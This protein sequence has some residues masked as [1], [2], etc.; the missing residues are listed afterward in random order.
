MKF[1]NILKW[2]QRF[3]GRVRKYVLNIE[4]EELWKQLQ[5]RISKQIITENSIENVRVI[6]LDEFDQE[7]AVEIQK[8]HKSLLEF[9]M[10]RN[11][12]NEVGF[13]VNLIDWTHISIKGSVNGVSMSTVPEARELLFSAPKNSLLFLH[14]HPN[15]SV[16]SEKDLESFLTADSILMVTVICNNGRQYFLTKT[17]DYQRE[18]ALLY[19]D[20]IYEKMEKGSVKEFLRTCSKAG[21]TF[22]YGGV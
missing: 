17:V 9:A 5:K 8:L 14:N 21:L 13:L 15:N 12:S 20:D 4:F 18:K 16:F 6:E 1:N 19:Y 2:D 11:E 3:K 10:S 22:Q 7:E